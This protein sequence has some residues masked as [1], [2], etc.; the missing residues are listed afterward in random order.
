MCSGR[1]MKQ[2]ANLGEKCC[3]SLAGGGEGGRCSMADGF[4]DTLGTLAWLRRFLGKSRN[5]RSETWKAIW[6]SPQPGASGDLSV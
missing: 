5:A 1:C 4:P 6:S 2:N 3:Q